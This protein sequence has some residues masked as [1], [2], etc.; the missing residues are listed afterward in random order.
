MQPYRVA[1]PH[2][3]DECEH[4]APNG[5]GH[6]LCQ[7]GSC[8]AH[9]EFQ[10]QR[11]ATPEEFAQIPEGLRPID[12]VA[13]RAV[14]VCADHQIDPD[15]DTH[16]A[17]CEGLGSCPCSPEQTGPD[18]EKYVPPV[19]N[20]AEQAEAMRIVHE[21]EMAFYKKI[22]AEHLG[23][24]DAAATHVQRVFGGFLEQAK[25]VQAVKDHD[26]V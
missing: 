4:C 9:A 14:F 13:R 1:R 7:H 8:A 23:D 12:G 6:R 15:V 22:V 11:H 19:E 16:A 18:F 17:H 26:S 10:Y 3:G 24:V 25:Q 21:A 2:E 20:P 5:E